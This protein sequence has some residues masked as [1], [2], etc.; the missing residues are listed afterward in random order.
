MMWVKFICLVLTHPLVSIY[1]TLP[2]LIQSSRIFMTQDSSLENN[3]PLY[4]YRG[5]DVK[6]LRSCNEEEWK[7]INEKGYDVYWCLQSFKEGRRTKDNIEIFRWVVA[8]FDNITIDGLGVQ[9]RS[10]PRPT[11][12]VKTGKGFHCYWKLKEPMYGS[13]TLPKE[14]SEFFERSLIPIGADPNAKDIC[15]ILRVP[16]SRYWQDSKGNRYEDKE[17]YCEVI[18]DDG[19]EWE[20]EQLRRLFKNSSG[21]VRPVLQE[22]RVRD[23]ET[24]Q[25]PDYFWRSANQVDVR[26]GLTKLSGST[27]VRGETYKFLV[28]GKITRIIINGKPSNAWIDSKGRIGSL[29]SNGSIP[30]AGTLV[31]WLMFPD[32][33]HDMKSV[34]KIFKEVFGL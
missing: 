23:R 27:Y 1:Q 9:F 28:E 34:A 25:T 29:H 18:Y 33:G 14:Y 8:D 22:P 24:L 19:P 31:N 30:I 10:S 13:A 11:M 4:F 21:G 6:D 3:K 17:I 32:Y 15:R 2:Y 12:V 5:M 26:E 16:F 20:W 7:E